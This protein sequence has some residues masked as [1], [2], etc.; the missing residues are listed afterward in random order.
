MHMKYEYVQEDR[1]VI[2]YNH[3]GTLEYWYTP[4]LVLYSEVYRFHRTST[5][6]DTER[7]TV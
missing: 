2:F 3:L 5:Q 7:R 4:A 6:N 1:T